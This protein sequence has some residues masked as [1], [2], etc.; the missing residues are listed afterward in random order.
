MPLDKSGTQAAV[1][2]NMRELMAANKR[3]PNGKKRSRRQMI[4]IALHAG[5]K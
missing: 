1:A 3:L 5:G 4:A 2:K